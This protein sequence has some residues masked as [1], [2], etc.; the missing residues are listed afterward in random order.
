ML[1]QVY[2]QRV[3][4]KTQALHVS[5][6]SLFWERI[7]S[8]CQPFLISSVD[9]LFELLDKNVEIHHSSSKRSGLSINLLIERVNTIRSRC[10]H[11]LH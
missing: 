3:N 9:F 8:C 4:V 1:T 11:T 5:R 7:T 2:E 6:A 10:A